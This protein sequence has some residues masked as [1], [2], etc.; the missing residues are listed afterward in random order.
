MY[1]RKQQKLFNQVSFLR[2]VTSES[3]ETIETIETGDYSVSGAW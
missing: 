3:D 1:Q 2:L